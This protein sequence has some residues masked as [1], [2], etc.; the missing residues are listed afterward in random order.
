M[1][2][3]M[4]YKITKNP[5]RA[6]AAVKYSTTAS[7]THGLSRTSDLKE[8]GQSVREG[9]MMTK[10]RNSTRDHTAHVQRG[11]RMYL[12]VNK[13]PAKCHKWP[14]S[15]IL[16][17]EG[18]FTRRSNAAWLRFSCPCHHSQHWQPLRGRGE[19]KLTAVESQ[20]EL[21]PRALGMRRDAPPERAGVTKDACGTS[22]S[23]TVWS[24]CLA[25]IVV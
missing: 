24:P 1:S 20:N 17:K 25:W 7:G 2:F 6:W 19:D 10:E 3:K 18:A 13:W 5:L 14:C 12:R 8:C 23:Y 11:R 16:E 21:V 9:T 4:L 15:M 22:L